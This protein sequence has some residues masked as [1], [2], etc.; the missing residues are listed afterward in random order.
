[1]SK[2]VKI[3]QACPRLEHLEHFSYLNY[4][5]LYYE[6]QLVTPAG[7]SLHAYNNLGITL[8]MMHVS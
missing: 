8:T 2:L 4:L 3:C 5:G 1:M 6:W 7:P